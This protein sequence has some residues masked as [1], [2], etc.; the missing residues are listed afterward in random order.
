MLWLCKACRERAAASGDTA[1]RRNKNRSPIP[2]THTNKRGFVQTGLGPQQ[3]RAWENKEQHQTDKTCYRVLVFIWACIYFF[4]F[5]IIEYN[6]CADPFS[7]SVGDGSK[8]PAHFDSWIQAK[9]SDAREWYNLKIVPCATV[10]FANLSLT[11]QKK[12]CGGGIA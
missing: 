8:A 2:E 6:M 9:S 10:C 7:K 4:H 12:N 3:R 11:R 1:K 5:E